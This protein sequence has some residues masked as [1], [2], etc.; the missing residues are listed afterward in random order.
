MTDNPLR[1]ATEQPVSTFS[2][3]VDTGAYANV[4]RFLQSGRLPVRDAVRTEELVN[5]F[6]Y[7]YPLPAQPSPPFR[8]TTELGT[9]PLEP[10]YRA[11]ASG[12]QR[13]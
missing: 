8:L 3:D 5:Y 10:A 7:Q 12:A 2:I 13:L 9:D 1:Q 4:R 11:A 6:A